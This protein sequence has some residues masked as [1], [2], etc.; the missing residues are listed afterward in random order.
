M[1]LSEPYKLKDVKALPRLLPFERVRALLAA[2]HNTFRLQSTQVTFDLVSRGT[3]AVSHFQKAALSVGDEAYAGA[4]N[5]FKLCANAKEVLGVTGIVPSHNGIGAEKLLA[6]TSLKKGQAVLHNM[7]RC[8]GLVPALGGESIECGAAADGTAAASADFDTG[9]VASILEAR[10]SGV[11]YVYAVTCPTWRNGLPL[12][13]ANLQAVSALCRKHKVML[14]L[15]ASSIMTNAWLDASVRGAG[16]DAPA[17]AK[18]MVALADV[19]VMDAGQDARC[20]IGGFIASPAQELYER[21]RNQVVMFEGLHTYGGMSGRAMEVFALGIAEMGKIEYTQWHQQQVSDLCARLGKAGVP[22]VRCGLGVALDV[23]KFLPHLPASQFPKFTLAACLYV[24]GGVRG[25]IEGLWDFH[26]TGAGAASLLLELPRLAFNRNHVNSVADAILSVYLQ[27]DTVKGLKLLNAPEFVDEAD[28]EPVGDR[29]IAPAALMLPEASRPYEPYRASAFEPLKVT[30]KEY[31]R[32]AIAAAGY[33]T[34]LLNS[35]DIYIDFLTDSGTAAMSTSQWEGMADVDETPYSSGA[36]DRLE[37]VFRDVLGYQHIIPTHQGR[38][39]EH[40]MSQVMIAPG[41]IVPGNMYFTTTKLHQELAGGIFVDIIVDE[42]HD[43]LSTFPWKGNIDLKKLEAEIARVGARNVAYISFEMSV[44][45]A[46]GQPFSMDNARD[47]CALCH[48]HGIPVM[49][50]ATRCVENAEMIRRKDPAYASWR[51]RDILRQ[52]LSYGDGCTISCKKDFL[53]NM[54][55]M[56]ACNNAD[57][58]HRF[59]RMLRVWE[60]DVTNG[61]M[62]VKD[63]EAMT[64]GLLESL[65]DDYIRMRIEQTQR[66]GQKLIDAGVPIVL[67]PGSH[68]IFIDAKRFLPHVDQEQYPAQALASAIF[69]ETG[70]RTMERGNVSKGRDPKTGQNYK[71]KLEL[72]RCTIPRRVYTPSHFDFIVEGVA[73]LYQHREQISG[74]KFTYEPPFLRFFQGRFEPLSTWTF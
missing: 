43:S 56:L 3:A 12:A 63:M 53:V 52:M 41:Q 51:V 27:R 73:R 2:G 23:A 13:L 57:L 16:R 19:V 50:D 25:C 45:M 14:V 42:A 44:N 20:D 70:V 35:E 67:P 1:M 72:V 74:L 18:Q 7:G 40:I 69:I 71:P 33:N 49:F 5:F 58:A 15:D 61:G 39:A 38:A 31:R 32:K 26:V 65:D 37:A 11:A 68:A 55:G 17:V 28:L 29:L 24:A 46:G 47:V 30:D 60:G 10:S 22:M 36:F 4:V 34:F 54:G 59:R 21:F 66:F 48:K 62:A 64:R 9:K 6:T 8:E